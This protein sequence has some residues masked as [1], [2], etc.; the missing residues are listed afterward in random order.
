[1]LEIGKSNEVKFK[2]DVNGTSA[3]PSVKFVLEAPDAELGFTANQGDGYWFTSVAIPEDFRPGDYGFRIEVLVNN[4]L[5][6]PVKKRVTVAGPENIAAPI[7]TPEPEV[8]IPAVPPVAMAQE[9][10]ILKP[11]TSFF[12]DE[13]TEAKQVPAIEKPKPAPTPAPK[14]ITP[15]PAPITK[16]AVRP[17]PPKLK[18][19]PMKLNMAE[20]VAES[21]KRFDKVLS[22]SQS[23]KSPVKPVQGHN[24]TPQTPVTLKKGEVVYE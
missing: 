2:V 23:Y 18:P 7:P 20:I 16:Q 10:I 3:S 15:Q 5:F 22:E 21:N 1:M 9:K 14:P 4:R 11:K 24:I 12:K 6:T 8:V 17:A 13:V 19:K